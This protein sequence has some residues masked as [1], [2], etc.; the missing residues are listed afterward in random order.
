MVQ[1]FDCVLH[2]SEGRV[3]GGE[4]TMIEDT[5]P[6]DD[7]DGNSKRDIFSVVVHKHQF[8]VPPASPRSLSPLHFSNG[9]DDKVDEFVDAAR[10]AGIHGLPG[11]DIQPID[12]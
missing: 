6:P 4:T 10:E 5:V 7:G 12:L 9:D 8:S 11:A 2:R 3:V 1:V